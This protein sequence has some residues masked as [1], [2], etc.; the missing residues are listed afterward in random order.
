MSM[1]AAWFLGF[2]IL[3][4]YIADVL[5]IDAEES[6]CVPT[7]SV[8]LTLNALKINTVHHARI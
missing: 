6:M 1:N 8:F 2:D 5:F 7:T 3:P 4:S